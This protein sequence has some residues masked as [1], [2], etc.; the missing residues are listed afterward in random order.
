MPV[1]VALMSALSIASWSARAEEPGPLTTLQAVDTGEFGA[2][3]MSSDRPAPSREPTEALVW[4]FYDRN[5]SL[6]R[7][8]EWD[9]SVSRVRFDCGAG[10][11]GNLEHQTFRDGQFVSTSIPPAVMQTPQ[12]PEKQALFDYACTPERSFDG[13]RLNSV[14]HARNWADRWFASVRFDDRRAIAAQQLWTVVQDDVSLHAVNVPPPLSPPDTPVRIAHWQIGETNEEGYDTILAMSSVDCR[15]GAVSQTRFS[16]YSGSRYLGTAPAVDTEPEQPEP[17][18]VFDAVV[19]FVCVPRGEDT[20]PADHANFQAA[21]SA[22]HA[23]STA[24]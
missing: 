16:G 10:T 4:A 23:G 2:F 18:T 5:D 21:Q 9:A 11:I 17:D 14:R 7:S 24:P 6:T 8:W 19:R 15:S 20:P 22:F 12:S 1:A 13:P 3:F